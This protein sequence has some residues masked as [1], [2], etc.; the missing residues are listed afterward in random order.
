MVFS[1]QKSSRELQ[2]LRLVDFE[3]LEIML[4]LQIL[5]DKV[6]ITFTKSKK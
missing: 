6:K 3:L 4:K 2:P 5:L 1:L